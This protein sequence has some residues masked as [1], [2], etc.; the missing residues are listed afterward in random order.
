MKTRSRD[1]RTKKR[2]V[3]GT[4]DTAKQAVPGTIDSFGTESNSSTSIE[5]LEN[6]QR[7]GSLPDTTVEDGINPED[8]PE[9]VWDD[10]NEEVCAIVS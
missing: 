2:V 1:S 3:D 7:E 6:P 8:A 4:A 5:N 10:T 9:V